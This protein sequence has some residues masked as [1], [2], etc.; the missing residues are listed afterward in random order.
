MRETIQLV[1]KFIGMISGA[2]V[3][4]AWIVAAWAPTPVL[5]LADVAF[6]VAMFMAVLAIIV[7][8]ASYHGH[9]IT[10]IVLFFASFFPIGV[11]LLELS[12]WVRMIGILNL[13]YL[14]AGLVAWRMPRST[15]RPD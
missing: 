3:C 2:A 6:A 8:I 11:F 12:G 14:I 15:N 4:A 7:V 13:G 5:E 10:L 9:G 1:G